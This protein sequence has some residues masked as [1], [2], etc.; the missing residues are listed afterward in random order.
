MGAPGSIL[1][2]FHDLDGDGK[3]DIVMGGHAELF[4]FRNTSTDF[5]G[6]V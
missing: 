5:R 3:E 1:L 2:D 6:S 4:F